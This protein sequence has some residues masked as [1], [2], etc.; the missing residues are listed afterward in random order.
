M[1]V[2]VDNVERQVTVRGSDAQEEYN[3]EIEQVVDKFHA[4]RDSQS[5]EERAH[6]PAELTTTQNDQS[7]TVAGETEA[8]E[9]RVE[10]KTGDKLRDVIHLTISI[11]RRRRRHV[12]R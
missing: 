5:G 7:Q 8:T 9:D 3:D 12:V 4:V 10:N 2:R 11:I 6:D 1:C